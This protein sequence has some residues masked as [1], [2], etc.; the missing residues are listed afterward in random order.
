ML[1]IVTMT[2][3]DIPFGLEMTNAESWGYLRDDFERLL[4]L[5]PEGC[6]VAQEDTALAG[7]VTTLWYNT[8]GFIGTLIVSAQFRGQNIG[9]KLM[10]HAIKYLTDR[11]V[12]T[13]ELDGVFPAAPL[14]RRLGFKDKYFSL[15]LQRQPQKSQPQ[16]I[17]AQPNKYSVNELIVFDTNL[18]GYDR[19]FLIQRYFDEFQGHLIAV[20]YQSINAYAFVKPRE[21]NSYSVGPFVAASEK[22]A[23]NVLETIVTKYSGSLITLGAPEINH[24]AIDLYR[25][26]GFIHTLPSLRMYYGNRIKL[27][28]HIFGMISAEKG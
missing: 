19:S 3:R 24:T 16:E 8:Y 2:H 25:E 15:R 26:S 11:G 18:A 14:Y 12:T 13:I 9:E 23:R 22:S 5:S 1:T 21:N 27:D 10:R 4:C 28:D 6:F 20:G 7:L 17:T